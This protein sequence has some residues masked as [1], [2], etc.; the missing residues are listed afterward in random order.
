MATQPTQQGAQYQGPERRR[1][2]RVLI[3]IPVKVQWAQADGTR[4][5]E[6][7]QTEIVNA[8]GALL[9]MK[10]P[11]F[12]SAKLELK[13]PAAGSSSQA[14]VVKVH[15]HRPDGLAR[16]AVELASPGQAFWGISIPPPS[17]QEQG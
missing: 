10:V 1:S 5:E 4:T 12:E 2:Q 15:P 17:P 3:V 7:A 13:R 16:V 14:R 9:R 8:H 11:P 6:D